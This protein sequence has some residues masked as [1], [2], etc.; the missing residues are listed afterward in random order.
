MLQSSR[1][2]NERTIQI[3]FHQ[4]LQAST[5]EIKIT[6]PYFVPPIRFI[7]RICDAAQRGVNVKIITCSESDVPIMAWASRHIYNDFLSNGVQI[8]EYQ[9]KVLHSKT[10][11]VDNIFSTFGSFNFD[12][13]SYSRNWE[14]NILMYDIIKAREL[15]EHFDEDLT[16]CY[17]ITKDVF[18]VRSMISRVFYWTAYQIARFPK[19]LEG[20]YSINTDPALSF[21]TVFS[22]V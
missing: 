10:M 15:S 13:W 21:Q 14:I 22:L 9:K 4:A 1:K 18:K 8:F 6:N 11:I 5:L 7:R 20:V 2:E 16:N 3:A 17:E 19:R 12:D